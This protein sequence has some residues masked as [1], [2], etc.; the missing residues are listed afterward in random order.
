MS[1]MVEHHFIVSIKQFG[2]APEAFFRP[3]AKVLAMRPGTQFCGNSECVL[4]G[5][6]SWEVCRK[7]GVGSILRW[8]WGTKNIE[9]RSSVARFLLM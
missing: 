2:I 4:P 7:K 1:M 6:G 5:L 9:T 3:M 8:I